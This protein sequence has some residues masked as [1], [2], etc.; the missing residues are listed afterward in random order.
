MIFADYFM[1]PRLVEICSSYLK[2]FVNVKTVLQIMLLAHAH[3][4]EQL[5]R[6]CI[7]FFALNEKE[8]VETRGWRHFKRQAQESLIQVFLQRIRDEQEESFVQIAIHNFITKHSKKD[9][10]TFFSKD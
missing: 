8:I 4:A 1:L 5:E 6:Y 3:N 2:Q 9:N 10:S 7:N